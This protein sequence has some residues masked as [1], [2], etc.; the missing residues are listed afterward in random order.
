MEVC[1][2]LALDYSFESERFVHYSLSA[3]LASM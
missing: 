2:S 1:L 3:Q